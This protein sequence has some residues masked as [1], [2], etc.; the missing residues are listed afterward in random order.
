MTDH[1]NIKLKA[2]AAHDID[3]LMKRISILL[4]LTVSFKPSKG[5]TTSDGL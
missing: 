3:R 4:S 1:K 5:T 2:L